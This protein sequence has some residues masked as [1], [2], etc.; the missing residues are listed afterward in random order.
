MCNNRAKIGIFVMGDNYTAS[1]NIL[2]HILVAVMGIIRGSI[3][4][5]P[6]KRSSSYGLRRIP[7]EVVIVRSCSRKV[8]ITNL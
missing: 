7:S 5:L 3:S 1:A 2:T 8:E 4:T 6:H